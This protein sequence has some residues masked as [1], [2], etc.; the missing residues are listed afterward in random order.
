MTKIYDPSGWLTYREILKNGRKMRKMKSVQRGILRYFFRVSLNFFR[1]L[2]FAPELAF[3]QKVNRFRGLLF[4]GINKTRNLHVT[5]KLY[6]ECFVFC[7]VFRKKHSQIAKS[8]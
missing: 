8:V 7:C 6:S 2:H 3:T 5:R 1:F 4:R